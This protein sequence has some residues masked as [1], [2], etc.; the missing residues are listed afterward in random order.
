MQGPFTI[1]PDTL[2]LAGE[3]SLSTA[4]GK[5]QAAYFLPGD[6]HSA[7]I[8]ANLIP[9]PYKG[10][11]ELAVRWVADEV[12][13]ARRNFTVT[14]AS[15]HTYYLDIDYLDTVA[16]IWL[17]GECVLKAENCFRRYRPDVTS[18]LR[19]GENEIE[20]RFLSNTKSANAK[21][22]Q[23]PFPIPYSTSNNPIPNGNMLRKPQCHFGWD[24]NL[25][26][27]PLGA[28][29]KFQLCSMQAFRIEHVVVQQQHDTAT[30]AVTIDVEV[31]LQ[32]RGDTEIQVMFAGETKSRRIGHTFGEA[33]Q[34]FRFRV[35]NPRLWWPSGHGEQTLYD[36]TV[37][38]ED[39]TVTRS[40]GLRH[41]E[42]VT[43]GADKVS[44]FAFK[45]NGREIFC[46]G[47]NWIPADALPANATPELTRELL[48]AAKDANMNMIRVWGGGYYEKDFFY[49]ICDE[50]GLLVWQDF[51]FA[52]SLY[53]STPD[54]LNEVQAEVSYQVKRLQHHAC[55]ALWCGDNE[56]IGA[57]TWF[58]ESRDNRDRYLVSYD[59]LNRLIET[60]LRS[61]DDRAL[62]WP[63][64]PSPGILDF[65]D[66]WHD[67]SKGDM[68]FWSVWHEGKS[69]EHYRD[70]TPRFCS[71]FGFQSCPSL[72]IAQQ[73]IDHED[74]LNIASPVMEHH[75][76][77]AGGNARI[78]ET[79]FRYFRFPMDFGNFVYLS[80][81]QQALAMRT[82]VEC[83]RSQKPNCMGTLYWQLN[84]TWPV[85]SWSGLD[86]GGGWK[87]LHYAARRFYAPVLVCIVPEKSTGDY[88][89]I[90]INDTGIP[91]SAEAD[92]QAITAAGKA[93]PLDHVKS[94][95]P[96]DRAIEIARIAREDVPDDSV[97]HWAWNT[98]SST[99]DNV[100]GRNHYSPQPYK[101]LPLCDPQLQINVNP[102]S[103]ALKI[104]IMATMP[105][106]FVCAETS[107]V[108]KFSDNCIDLLQGETVEIIF[109]PE[110]IGDLAA[111]MDSLRIRD[112]YTATHSTH[113]PK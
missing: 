33:R 52:C 21:Q 100:S 42:L 35:E 31:T 69:F 41:V 24:W 3:W 105:A 20:I 79:M 56:L 76:R 99:G 59:R 44:R 103:E 7:L 45:I 88:V 49:D 30:N 112:L 71:E 107:V 8:A 29:G 16:E 36:L 54:F 55:I 63:S 37:V 82:A 97:L 15:G 74:D 113:V 94:I 1:L 22:A 111:A 18:H 104:M 81:V 23:Q 9:H 34:L 80:Q 91:I 65:G 13:H 51:M 38:C 12:W 61:V 2:D 58:K 4:D 83:W 110:N 14:P 60:T 48:Q 73:F 53:P 90:G 19:N 96:P 67:D 78:A 109:T 26:I 106:L 57:L 70:V 5:H 92:I 72:R 27:V 95:L 98:S 108:G 17:N 50:L 64:S 47:A 89:V 87:L 77:N 85:A 102:D 66:T 11:N 86:H 93:T 75:Q 40:V 84:D 6:I 28:Y 46:R 32:G 62:W 101:A 25:A 10:K 43:T 68:H 39:Q